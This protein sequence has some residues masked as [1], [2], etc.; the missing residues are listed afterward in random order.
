MPSNDEVGV[1]SEI[2]S[3]DFVSLLPKFAS[4]SLQVLDF[5]KCQIFSIKFCGIT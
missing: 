2:F 3:P 4:Q 1:T 5:T